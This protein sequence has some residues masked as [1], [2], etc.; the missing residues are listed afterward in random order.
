MKII[1][2]VSPKRWKEYKNLRIEAL[3]NVPQAFLDDPTSS[4]KIAKKE[5]QRKMNNM[6]F[7][8]VDGKLIG[9]IGAYQDKKTKLK[10]IM[11]IVGFYVSPKHRNI[12]AG[13]ALLKQVIK[14][15]KKDDTIMKLQLG[16]V[17]TQLPAYR[18]YQ[19][20][21]FKKAGKLKYA[22]KVDKKYF[23]EYLMELCLN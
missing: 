22:V 11:N 13:K 21:G 14:N 17:T 1:K 5:W 19:K 6:Y 20:L 23:N 12:G 7:A 4:K 10:H 18:L 3:R 15:T 16:V 9:M 8:E 2:N